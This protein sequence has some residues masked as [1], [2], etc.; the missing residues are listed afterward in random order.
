MIYLDMADVTYARHGE[1]ISTRR[2]F[3]RIQVYDS[4]TAFKKYVCIG[5]SDEGGKAHIR[6]H[7]GQVKQI[8]VAL[9]KFIEY[10]EED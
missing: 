10:A 6:L 1:D 7:K 3:G 8:V 2:S 9:Q 4:N 5:F